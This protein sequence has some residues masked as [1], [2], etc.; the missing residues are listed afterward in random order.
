MYTLAG[1]YKADQVHAA[2]LIKRMG[3]NENTDLVPPKQQQEENQ[4]REEEL[5]RERQE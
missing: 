4:R 3:T 2:T 5:R 1:N